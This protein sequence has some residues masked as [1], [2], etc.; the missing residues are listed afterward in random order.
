MDKI[1]FAIPNMYE[2]FNINKEMLRII[3]I[4]PEILQD[5]IKID[6]F[7]GTFQY[8]I[9]EGGRQFQKYKQTTLEKVKEIKNYYN[10]LNIPIRLTYT[11]SQIKEEHLY[12]R[13]CNL[14][15]QECESELNEIVIN[16]PIL[17]KYIRNNYPKY[18]IISSTTKCIKNKELF[19]NELS[20]N[21][22]EI[23]L[24]FN[25]NHSFNLFKELTQEQKEKIEFLV[26]AVCGDG[27]EFRQQHYQLISDSNLN[28][29][30]PYKIYSCE[31]YESNHYPYKIGLNNQI[32]I[33]SIL[34][35]YAPL[36]FKHFKI[37]GRA[38]PVISHILSCANYIIKP[39]YKDYFIEQ[40]VNYILSLLNSDY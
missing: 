18:K 37:E 32:T 24:D 6:A 5:N 13:F 40:L 36:G 12:D 10:E 16:S 29:C 3:Q 17:E 8:S 15:T 31:L 22:Y 9:W 2:F 20:K 23:C 26:N 30:K 35:D 34:K 1:G 39:E 27:C 28:Y 19:L 25:L 11:N 21:Y 4:H 38:R 14:V 7:Y 33:D